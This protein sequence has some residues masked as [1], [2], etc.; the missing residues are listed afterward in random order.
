MKGKVSDSR[1]PHCLRPLKKA[2]YVF[3][4]EFQV[5]SFESFLNIK[6]KT[7]NSSVRLAL[8]CARSRT[9][10]TSTDHGEWS[11]LFIWFLKV[12][13][14]DCFLNVLEGAQVLDDIAAGVVKEDI[15]FTVAANGNQPFQLISIF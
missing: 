1:L 3:S 2:I 12:F 9:R 8:I 14:Q 4:F 6:L 5:P 7:G 10:A 13:S 11:A 15:A